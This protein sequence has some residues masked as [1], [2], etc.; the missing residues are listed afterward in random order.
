MVVIRVCIKN[1]PLAIYKLDSN[2]V[3]SDMKKQNNTQTLT[4]TP[5]AAWNLCGYIP[6]AFHT[7]VKLTSA[8]VRVSLALSASTNIFPSVISLSATSNATLVS[9]FGV[10]SSHVIACTI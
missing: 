2:N 4:P 10:S 8:S 9:L 7:F 6:T 5:S 1:T 3:K